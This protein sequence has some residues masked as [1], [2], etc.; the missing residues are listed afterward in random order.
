MPNH[1]T[2]KVTF[3]ADQADRVF[4]VVIRD[5][6]F[7][8]NT[9]VPQPPNMYHGDLSSED[10]KD[11]KVNWSNWNRENWGTKWGAYQCSHGIENDRAFVKFDTAWS[12]PYPVMAAFC[13]RF[14]IPFEH[15]YFD[16]GENF[17]GIDTWGPSR[18]GDHAIQRL[19]KR[20]NKKE[21]HD[22]LAAELK[23][24]DATY[25][26]EIAAEESSE[27]EEVSRG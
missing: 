26:A 21:D 6:G 12:P 4:A 27:S 24:R 13:N 1:V 20:Y 18:W 11:F 2:N 9:L 22:A 17:W 19:E 16:E 23:G 14:Q 10:D 15:R 25:Y 7:D 8:F 3:A 5:D